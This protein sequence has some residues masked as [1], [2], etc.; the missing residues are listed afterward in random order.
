VV[1]RVGRGI[2]R[3]GT[4]SE[5]GLD[6][7]VH[8]VSRLFGYPVSVQ[9][10][11]TSGP[12]HR[13]R[14]IVFEGRLT[15]H[16]RPMR[17][18]L[19]VR[20]KVIYE[21][22]HMI[23]RRETKVAPAYNQSCENRERGVGLNTHHV[24]AHTKVNVIE[25]SSRVRVCAST[26]VSERLCKERHERGLARAWVNIAHKDDTVE[27]MGRGGRHLRLHFGVGDCEGRGSLR[28]WLGVTVHLLSHRIYL[29]SFL[30][31]THL[32]WGLHSYDWYHCMYLIGSHSFSLFLL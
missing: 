24:H 32:L 21:P 7:L 10:L 17:L 19:G 31:R 4:D 14:L 3:L 2:R 13:D 1:R 28:S 30:R 16:V 11:L 27:W 5:L 29:F 8:L 23:R 18:S 20:A 22:C 6:G 15:H 26:S 25:T 9:F 12:L